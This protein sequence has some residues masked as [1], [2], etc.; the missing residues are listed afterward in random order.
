MINIYHSSN[1]LAISLS[2]SFILF[3]AS[4]K[5][6]NETFFFI[7]PAFLFW[8]TFR[9]LIITMMKNKRKSYMS[10]NILET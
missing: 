6:A 2:S 7:V 10:F 4:L 3:F 9:R 5:L 1:N 8:S